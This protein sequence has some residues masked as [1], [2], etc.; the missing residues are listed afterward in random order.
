LPSGRDWRSR[1]SRTD[2]LLPLW[3]DGLSRYYN[4]A[5]EASR[6]LISEAIISNYPL[7]DLIV[8]MNMCEAYKQGGQLL[9]ILRRIHEAQ[10]EAPS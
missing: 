5:A 9:P 1:L 6:Q 3:D 10:A 8:N 2:G 7:D 4:V